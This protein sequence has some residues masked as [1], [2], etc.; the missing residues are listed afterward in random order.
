VPL[1]LGYH[2][3]AEYTRAMRNAIL[4]F[5]FLATPVIAQETFTVSTWNIENFDHNFWAYHLT[6]PKEGEKPLFDVNSDEGKEAVRRIREVNDEDNW[7]IAQTILDPKFSPDVLVIQECCSQADLEFFNRRWLRSAYETVIVFPSNTE[8]GQQLGL[9]AKKG[10][11]IV[12]KKAEYYLEKDTVPNERGDRVFARGPFFLKMK[13]PGGYSFWVGSNHQKSK[14][15]NSLAATQWRNREAKRTHQILLE[16]EKAGPDD[17]IFLGDMNDSLGLDEF[18]QKP[19]SGGDVIANLAG[20]ENDGVFLATR[21][22]AEEGKQSY[23]GYFREDRRSLID[24]VL[25]TKGMKDQL[26]DIAIVDLPLARVASD[27]LPVMTK[28][29]ADPAK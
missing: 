17:V 11:S 21:K 18:E 9:L 19:D 4:F 8:R 20:P 24:H 2:I 16:L 26:A 5:I 27:H 25:M 15:G 3:A 6:H 13:T 10:F 1:D 29:K 23:L 12:E 7:E 28:I 22:L 14:S